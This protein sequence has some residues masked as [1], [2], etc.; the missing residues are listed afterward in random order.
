MARLVTIEVTGQARQ[1]RGHGP[2]ISEQNNKLYAGAQQGAA[3][4][5]TSVRAFETSPGWSS[6]LLGRLG[7]GLSVFQGLNFLN[8]FTAWGRRH[9]FRI[10]TTTNCRGGSERIGTYRQTRGGIIRGFHQRIEVFLK[11]ISAANDPTSEQAEFFKQL[12][13]DISGGLMPTMHQLA[14]RLKYNLSTTDQMGVSSNCLV[15]AAKTWSTS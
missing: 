11:A 14:D 5:A 8:T 12:N 1:L 6:K 9:E 7:I 13:I 15:K 10:E 2:R 3:Q 4:A